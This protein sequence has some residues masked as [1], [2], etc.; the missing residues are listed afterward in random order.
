V[1]GPR[2][3]LAAA[4]LLVAVLGLTFAVLPIRAY[5][6]GALGWVQAL[7]FWAPAVIV[8]AYILASLFCIPGLLLS[9]GSGFLFGLVPGAVTASIGTTL[10]AVAAFLLGRS[11]MRES[12]QRMIVGD[13]RFSALNWAV[14]RE[15]FKVVLLARLS[16]I[17]PY[18]LLNY[19]LALTLV[20][21]RDFALAS[22]IG[23]FPL[24]LVYVY[25]GST[26]ANLAEIE[27][28]SLQSSNAGWFLSALGLAATVVIF[29]LL[30]RTARRAF[31]QAV[32]QR[33]ALESDARG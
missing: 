33:V 20:R 32:D 9:I 29:V 28:A 7:G 25:L 18:N 1:T 27:T 11:L 24:T 31:G 13:A 14:G 26:L 21:F 22:W 10:G 3:K 16:P 19:A 30:A 8:A 6:A 12:I 2:L 23:M 15:G 5:L 17:L 4:T